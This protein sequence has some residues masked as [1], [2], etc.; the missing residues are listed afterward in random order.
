MSLG[1]SIAASIDGTI[2]LWDAVD[3]NLEGKRHG[4]KGGVRCLSYAEEG[5]LLSG[6]YDYDILGWDISGASVEP[7][8]RLGGGFGGHKFPVQAISH[9]PGRTQVYILNPL[10]SCDQTVT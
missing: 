8:F 9:I 3:R 4:H 2:C 7:L 6:G 1:I 5:I 10:M